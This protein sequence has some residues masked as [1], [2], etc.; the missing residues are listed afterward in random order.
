LLQKQ[1]IFGLTAFVDAGRVWSEIPGSKELDGTSLGLKV[2]VGGGARITAGGSFVLR[3]DV[4]WSKDAS[5]IA[6]YLLAGQMF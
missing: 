4:A 1:N 3:A 6:A 5:P 2:G